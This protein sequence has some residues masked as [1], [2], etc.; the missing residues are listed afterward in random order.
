MNRFE[1]EHEILMMSNSKYRQ[2]VNDFTMPK[3]EVR[4]NHDNF[5][6]EKLEK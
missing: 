1:R 2:F 3:G 5:N 4:R 6:W